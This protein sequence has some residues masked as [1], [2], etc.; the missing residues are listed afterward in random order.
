MRINRERE[1]KASPN[2]ALPLPANRLPWAV[3]REDKT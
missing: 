3:E 2:I 1:D